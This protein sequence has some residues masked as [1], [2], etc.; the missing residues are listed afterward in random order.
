MLLSQFYKDSEADIQTE[1]KTIKITKKKI[2]KLTK[3]KPD[4]QT[5]MK[6]D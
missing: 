1:M 5:E 4:K 3:K 2:D 6:T